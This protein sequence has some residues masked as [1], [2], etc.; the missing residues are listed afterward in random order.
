MNLLPEEKD[1]FKQEWQKRCGDIKA[2]DRTNEGL[3]ESFYFQ[4]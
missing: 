3:K 2:E 4:R 1:R